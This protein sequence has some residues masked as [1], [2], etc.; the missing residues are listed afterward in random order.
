MSRHQSTTLKN[1]GQS[2]SN[3]IGAQLLLGQQGAMNAE[4][5]S[6]MLRPGIRRARD[7]VMVF[8]KSVVTVG[9][10]IA[11]VQSVYPTSMLRLQEQGEI[12]QL[13]STDNVE[14]GRVYMVKRNP[15]YC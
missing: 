3:V 14:N 10:V 7:Q 8:D 4:E 6:D 9:E 5:T 2:E 12:R 1:V 13:S 15:V 11:S